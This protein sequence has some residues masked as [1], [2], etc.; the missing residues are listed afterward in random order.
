MDKR[1]VDLPRI[2]GCLFLN[3]LFLMFAKVEKLKAIWTNEGR[4]CSIS[5]SIVKELTTLLG[6]QDPN[7]TIELGMRYGNPSIKNALN[8]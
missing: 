5:R 4:P 7:F 3:Q 2:F 6:K 8:L 1:V